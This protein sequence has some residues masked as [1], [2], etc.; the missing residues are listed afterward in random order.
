MKRRWIAALAVALTALVAASWGSGLFRDNDRE[1]IEIDPQPFV[2]RVRAPGEL[3]SSNNASIGCPPIRR[4]W[5]FNIT[6][7]ADEGTQVEKGQPVVSF[8]A[9]RLTDRLEIVRS[10]LD[11]SRSEL[12]RTRLEQKQKVEKLILEQAE[13]EARRDK[14]KQKLVV[15][16]AMQARLE[17]EK[18]RLDQELV[19]EELRLIGARLET[20]KENRESMTRASEIRVAEYEREAQWLEKNIEAMNVL[21]PRS[22][23]VVHAA[24]WNGQKAKVGE[25]VWSGRSILEVAD[26]SNM[27]VLAQVAERDAR[28][29]REGMR[30]EVR[31]D[32]SPD[33]VFAGA[34]R[35]IG[36]LFH[37]KS[38]DVPTMIFDVVI[39][40]DEPDTEL[41]RPG[42][43]A[44][45]EILASSD[46]PLI[47]LPESAIR[48]VDGRPMVDV[49][50]GDRLEEVPLTLGTRFDGQVV[51]ESGL[52]AGDRVAARTGAGIDAS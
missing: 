43:K 6:W 25:T 41:M 8:D 22:G 27:E 51:V 30:A 7:L 48:V 12:E 35:R 26:L 18:I 34:V 33:R 31:L 3:R 45:V 9:Q 16:E 20:Q 36:K 4:M 28:Y 38:A 49:R 40:V 13:A 50:R 23:F 21:A 42:M 32:A 10:R 52:R 24:N 39:Q 11:T 29:V 44:S 47:Q 17:L 37:T 19:E 2:R 14:L 5:D 1:W 15:P 46:E